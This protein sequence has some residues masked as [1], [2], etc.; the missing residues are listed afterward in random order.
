MWTRKN[1]MNLLFPFYLPAQTTAP[2]FPSPPVTSPTHPSAPSRS[3]QRPHRPCGQAGL[4]TRKDPGTQASQSRMTR[5][6]G[7]DKWPPSRLWSPQGDREEVVVPVSWV[8]DLVCDC[9]AFR[10]FRQWGHVCLEDQAVRNYV[11]VPAAWLCQRVVVTC[12]ERD[13]LSLTNSSRSVRLRRST[14]ALSLGNKVTWLTGGSLV[15]P[16]T[17]PGLSRSPR[18]REPRFRETLCCCFGP[19]SFLE[20]TAW[21][22]H[23]T[24][25]S[26]ER[27]PWVS[28]PCWGLWGPSI[29]TLARGDPNQTAGRWTPI[30]VLAIDHPRLWDVR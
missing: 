21:R 16:P 8:S 27:C 5:E 28:M 9:K 3:P 13:F 29:N 18:A 14:N 22:V 25:V 26:S 1:K 23:T 2:G 15:L 24:H 11:P 20:T 12:R 19:L 6:D 10:T 30:T 17:A 7:V 4:S